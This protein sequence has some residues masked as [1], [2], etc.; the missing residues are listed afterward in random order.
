M[1]DVGQSHT[2]NTVVTDTESW[3]TSEGR[4]QSQ[5]QEG[6]PTILSKER[7]NRFYKEESGTGRADRHMQTCVHVITRIH[8]HRKATRDPK[9]RSG[10]TY[11]W[12]SL[13]P[14]PNTKLTSSKKK[15]PAASL[16]CLPW[17]P[18]ALSSHYT[19][20]FFPKCI[21]LSLPT[22]ILSHTH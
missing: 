22:H 11:L 15:F 14:N 12:F 13:F 5:G 21:L 16:L 10:E 9:P 7:G 18:Q 6:V 17:P 3:L 1:Q 8:I 19:G 4:A 2:H 20:D